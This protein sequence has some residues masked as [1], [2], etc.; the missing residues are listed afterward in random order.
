MPSAGLSYRDFACRLWLPFS[1]FFFLDQIYF[2]QNDICGLL[3]RHW[4]EILSQCHN[5]T[6]YSYIIIIF[7]F[8]MAEQQLPQSSDIIQAFWQVYTHIVHNVTLA[9]SENT[10]STV[11]A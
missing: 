6:L 10:D 8:L 9:L 1:F 4:P 2:K 11:L 3:S 5:V 7:L